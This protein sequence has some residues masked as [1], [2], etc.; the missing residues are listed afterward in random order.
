MSDNGIYFVIT[1][2]KITKEKGDYSHRVTFN[3]ATPLGQMLF[4]LLFSSSTM[5]FLQQDCLSFLLG[6]MICPFVTM[7]VVIF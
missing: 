5:L 2:Q 7:Y 4:T 3:G 6:Q 1:W